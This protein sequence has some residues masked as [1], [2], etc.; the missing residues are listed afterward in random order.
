MGSSD[1]NVLRGRLR[2]GGGVYFMGYH[3]LYAMASGVFRMREKPV[4]I[5]GLLIIAGYLRAAL[6]RTPRYEYPGFRDYL[7][8]WQLDKLKALVNW[9]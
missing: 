7:H 9:R 6:Q 8:K 2:W 3:P 4:I 5:G 1:K